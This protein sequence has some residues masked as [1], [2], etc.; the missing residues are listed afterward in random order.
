MK[1]TS[2]NLLSYIV[3][4]KWKYLLI[5]GRVFLSFY[6]MC[7]HKKRNFLSIHHVNLI[8][9]AI[10]KTLLIKNLYIFF[11]KSNLYS[12][13]IYFFISYF[14][15]KIKTL[16]PFRLGVQDIAFSRRKHGFKSRK[17]YFNL[18]LH[19]EFFKKGFSWLINQGDS[20]LFYQIK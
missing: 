17:G 15:Y 7:N 12:H 3:L 2:S 6:M 14:F 13:K 11:F 1:K 4:F 16:C 20:P 5:K 8:F 9:W 10:C 19:S 18:L